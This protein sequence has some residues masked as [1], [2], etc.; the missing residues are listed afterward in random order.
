MTKASNTK[1]PD[2]LC[3]YPNS[4][5]FNE[6]ILRQDVHVS[7][8]GK[9]RN[10]VEEFCIS[11]GWARV[12]LNNKTRDRYGRPMTLKITGEIKAWIAS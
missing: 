4:P 2:H 9:E 12:A 3:I 10:D 5:Y 8:N 6:E 7:I 1:I 11:E